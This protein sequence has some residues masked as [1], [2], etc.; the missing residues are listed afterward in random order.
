MPAQYTEFPLIFHNAENIKF[1]R[2]ESINNLF[3]ANY[4]IAYAV[5]HLQNLEFSADS[6]HCCLLHV[7]FLLKTTKQLMEFNC[8]P[9]N[10]KYFYYA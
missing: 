2:H 8:F 1:S 4:F 9:S 7:F 3:A 5:N 6:L 10:P